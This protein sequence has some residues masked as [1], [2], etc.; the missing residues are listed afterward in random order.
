MSPDCRIWVGNNSGFSC[1]SFFESLVGM[2]G[3]PNLE[4]SQF[5]WKSGVPYRIKV[6]AWLVFH[7]NL[8]TCDLVPRRNSHLALSP[9]CCVMCKEEGVTLDHL[10]LHCKVARGLWPKVLTEA[11]FLWAFPAN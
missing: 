10:M 4:P 3:C 1:K 8:N 2:E 7:G 9:S 11:G 6:F 5:I